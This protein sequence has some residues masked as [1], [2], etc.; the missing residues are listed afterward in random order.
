M[1]SSS[2]WIFRAVDAA[3]GFLDFPV[4]GG[5]PTD[6]GLSQYTIA[7]TLVRR[8]RSARGV[9]PKADLPGVPRQARHA[10][11]GR[12]LSVEAK[13]AISTPS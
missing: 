7:R 9:T 3:P 8:R 10:L 6:Q 12:N 13:A 2:S 11:S 1:P 4:Q 5:D